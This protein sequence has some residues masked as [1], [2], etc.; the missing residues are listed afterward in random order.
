MGE[1]AHNADRSA[2][3]HGAFAAPSA[4]SGAGASMARVGGGLALTSPCLCVFAPPA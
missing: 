4:V 3:A 2:S 1:E